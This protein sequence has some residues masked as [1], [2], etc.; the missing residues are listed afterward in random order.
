MGREGETIR[1]IRTTLRIIIS[2]LGFPLTTALRP[3]TRR[4]SWTLFWKSASSV[5]DTVDGS[6]PPLTAASP[7]KIWR[8]EKNTKLSDVQLLTA[9][10]QTAGFPHAPGDWLVDL[11]LF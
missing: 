5:A 7:A 9:L 11:P 8:R 1:I 10:C 4:S 3:H 2:I 6:T